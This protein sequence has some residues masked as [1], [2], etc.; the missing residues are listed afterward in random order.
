MSRFLKVERRAPRHA[1]LETLERRDL[2][3]ASVGFLSA[4]SLIPSGQYAAIHA[5]AVATDAAGDTVVTG[6]FRGTVSFD[7]ASSNA[8]YTTANTQDAFVAEY[9]P[10]GALRWARTFAGQATTAGGTTNYAVGQGSALALDASGDVFVAGSFT[11]TVNFGTAASPASQ[12]SP[13]NAAAFVA[14]LGPTGSLVWASHASAGGGDDSADGIALDGSGGAVIAGSYAVAA[15]FGATTLTAAG[16]SEAFAARVGPT[17]QFTWAVGSK[18][19]SGSNAAARGVA[20][21]PSGNVVL[22]G[23]L[24]GQVALIPGTTLTAQGSDDAAVWKLNSAG[25][26]LW[27]RSFGSADHDSADALAVDPGG[28]LLVAGTFSDSV[29]FATAPGPSASL[30]AGPIFDGYALKLDPNGNEAWVAGFVGPGGW[31]RAE[32]IAVGIGGNLFIAGTF[33]GTVDFDPGSAADSLTSGGYTDAFA[34]AL[35][36]SGNLISALHAGQ[37]NANSAEGIA[38]IGPDSVAI[39]GTYSAAIAFGP[40]TLPTAP[41]S[42]LYVASALLATNPPATPAAPVLEAG[43]TTGSPNTTSNTAPTFDVA[44]T[45]PTETVELLRDST[46]VGQRLGTGA[47]RDAGPV[48][49]GV[50]VYTA[51]QVAFGGVAGSPSTGTSVTFLTTP[52]AAP[53]APSLLPG[54]DSGVLGD[55][56]TNVRQPHLI[57]TAYAGDTIQLVNP[58]GTLFGSAVAGTNGAYSIPVSGPLADGTYSLGV[59]AIDA[60]NNVGAVSLYFSLRIL[61]TAPAAPGPITLLASDDSG[62]LGDGI[63]DVRAPRLVVP[64]AAGL[65]VEVENAAGTILGSATTSASGSCTVPIASPLADGTYPLHAVAVDPAGNVS[66]AGGTFNLTILATPPAAPGTPSLLAADDSGTLGDGITNMKGPRLVV[67]AAAGLT[68]EVENAAGTIL[69]SASSSTGSYTVPVAQPLADGTYPLH[70]V[71]VDVAGNVSAAGGTFKLVILT[72]APTLAAPA[73]LASD[74]T[75]TLGDGITTL[76]RPRIVGVGSPG[77]QVSWIGPSGATLATTT[78]SATGSYTLQ[79]PA[80][81]PDGTTTARVRE[82]DV[83]GNVGPISPALGLTIRVA[84][85]DYY[86]DAKTDLAIFQP[87]NGDFYILDPETNALVVR[88]WAISGDVPVAGDFNGNGHSEIAVYRPSTSTFYTLDPVTGAYATIQWGAAGAIPVPGDYDGD[89]KADVAIYWPPASSFYVLDSSTSSFYGHQI[90]QAGDIPVPA[91]YFGTGHADLAVYRPSNSTFYVYDPVTGA[92]ETVAWGK[93][94]DIPMP[95]DYFGTG[96]ADLAV[97]QPGPNDTYIIQQPGATAPYTKAFGNAGDVPVSGDYFG[98]GH[99]NLAVYRP[100]NSTFYAFDPVTGAFAAFQWGAANSSKPIL[101]TITAQFSPSG[102]PSAK[103]AHGGPTPAIVPAAVP[104]PIEV[105]PTAETTPVVVTP[106]KNTAVIDR[107]LAALSLERW[108]PGS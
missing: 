97:I 81:L 29:N 45:D 98:Q 91:D 88:N 12:S 23:I 89:G 35:G 42:G 104:I 16:A 56:I 96:R 65:T 70:A 49:Q 13:G 107:A 62:T 76:P 84:P 53:A 22:A 44:A 33:N 99:A 86:G 54:D 8:T 106:S 1:V 30:T 74:D 90:G 60:A 71:A 25:A 82:V 39:A 43:S 67:P 93:A 73:L 95:A 61:A 2:P 26:G 21:D 48:P 36:A 87:T 28:N 10:A 3:T 79:L 24:S 72:A 105:D 11:G 80:S 18:G 19:S 46:V 57:G 9:S 51:E 103:A 102:T 50:H 75:G 7:P 20:V 77:G 37:A 47:I 4:T 66:P 63:T 15:S 14:K 32:G 92:S 58:A 94:G 34:L 101:P 31:S 5:N 41:N 68:V 100:S 55:G 85:G 78:A 64:A 52:P 27:S 6:S 59:R 17:G 108:R 40:T 69:A 83:A 38:A